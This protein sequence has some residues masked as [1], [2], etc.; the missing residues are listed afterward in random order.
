[1]AKPIRPTFWAFWF[2]RYVFRPLCFRLA[3]LAEN[4]TAQ[5]S[6]THLTLSPSGRL[7]TLRCRPAV[8]CPPYVLQHVLAF[9]PNSFG[10]LMLRRASPPAF[11]SAPLRGY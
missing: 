9:L 6:V 10:F 5:R 8:G 11:Q 3:P 7:P 4:V 1:S 2:Y